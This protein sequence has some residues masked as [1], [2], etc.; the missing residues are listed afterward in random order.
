MMPKDIRVEDEPFDRLTELA[1]QMGEILIQPGNE[2]V[3]GII[4]LHD[5]KRGGIEMIGYEEVSEGMA[6]LLVHMKAVFESQ[7]KSFGVM[8]D[9]GVL[10][11]P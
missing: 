1:A 3:K 4:F 2:D 7:G 5:S 8:T 11:A 6:D 10:L 9:Q